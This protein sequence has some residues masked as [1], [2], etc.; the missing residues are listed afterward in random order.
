MRKGAFTTG[1][2]TC[3]SSPED[4][5]GTK[6]VPERGCRLAEKLMVLPP[7]QLSAKLSAGQPNAVLLMSE[8]WPEL[9]RNC[10][11]RAIPS[12]PKSVKGARVT[13]PTMGMRYSTLLIRLVSPPG[14]TMRC[15]GTG[16]VTLPS[17][18]LDGSRGTG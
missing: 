4:I 14:N 3:N 7:T 16:T 6:L 13:G 15:T 11:V 18:G 1:R 2:I 9:M 8:S 12:K 17:R 10:E 5:R